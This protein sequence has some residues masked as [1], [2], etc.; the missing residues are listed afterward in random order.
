MG[1]PMVQLDVLNIVN[2]VLT[3]ELLIG[4]NQDVAKFR[5][6][7]N[8]GQFSKRNKTKFE[9]KRPFFSFRKE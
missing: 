8:I 9:T 7:Y 4:K 3:S 6:G 1:E 5:S 2:A